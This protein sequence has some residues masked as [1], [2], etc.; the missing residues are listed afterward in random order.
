MDAMTEHDESAFDEA[1]EALGEA[2][3][4]IRDLIADKI[5]YLHSVHGLRI[6]GVVSDMLDK[7]ESFHLRLVLVPDF[8]MQADQVQNEEG[9]LVSVAEW[10]E[11]LKFDRGMLS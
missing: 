6:A 9:E 10:L 8:I 2:E 1:L 11:G 4:E 3:E 7:G 5:N